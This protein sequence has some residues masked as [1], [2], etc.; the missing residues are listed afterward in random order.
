MGLRDGA[1]AALRPV[2][3]TLDTSDGAVVDEIVLASTH[4]PPDGDQCSAPWLDG[5]VLWQPTRTALHRVVLDGFGATEVMSLPLFHDLHSVSPTDE[6]WLLTC[7][8]HETVIEVDRSGEVRRRWSFAKAP[9]ERDY[10]DLAHDA[11]KPHRWHPNYT[12]TWRGR[13]WVTL[14]GAQQLRCLD[15]DEWVPITEGPPH[16]GIIR[17]GTLWITTTNGRVLGLDPDTF[18]RRVQ[19]DVH[20]LVPERGLPGWCRGI[21]V[22]GDRV[23]VGMT[24]FR[25]SL[26]REAGRMALRGRDG[27]KQPTRVVELDW[28]RGQGGGVWPVG[29]AAG[30]SIYGITALP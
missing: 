5:G 24:M 19:L 30:G 17:D 12:W 15:D 29:N 4:P 14:L 18:E 23:F 9:D 2:L 25:S 1:G 8:G 13:R 7:T 11:F 20:A 21:E 28:R 22:V 10:R 26:W 3:R 6:G 16:D 27:V